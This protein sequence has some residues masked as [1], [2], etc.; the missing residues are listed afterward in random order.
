MT[1]T[2]AFMALSSK[3]VQAFVAAQ[4]SVQTFFSQYGK[5]DFNITPIKEQ[6]ESY[7]LVVAKKYSE[8]FTKV[9]Q[10]LDAMEQDGTLKII[11]KK[12]NLE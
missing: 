3:R 2:E 6:T 7:S 12:W 5:Q 11:R 4:S 10:I 8:L 9:Q 1:P